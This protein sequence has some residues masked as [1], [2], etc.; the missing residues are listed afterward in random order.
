MANEL[1]DLIGPPVELVDTKR[2]TAEQRANAAAAARAL[3]EKDEALN[4][5]AKADRKLGRIV[6]G[7]ADPVAQLKAAETRRVEAI[8]PDQERIR[9]YRREVDG[10]LNLIND[11]SMQ[12][13]ESDGDVAAFV[14]KRLRPAYGDLE[15]VI[16]AITP[17]GEVPRG[18]IG[19]LSAPGIGAEKSEAAQ[20]VRMMMER[21]ATQ[22]EVKQ[23]T[24]QE[25][26]NMVKELSGNSGK[27]DPMMVM[28]MP[29]L[30]DMA[31]PQQDQSVMQLL[32]QLLMK[33]ESPQPPPP[34]VAFPMPESNQ[35]NPL[36]LMNTVLGMVNALKP[37]PP[38]PTEPQPRLL[39]Q[40][41]EAVM[42]FSPLIVPLLPKIME[43]F[44]GKNELKHQLD[45]MQ[46]EMRALR[47]KPTPVQTTG[48]SLGEMLREFNDIKAMAAQISPPQPQP[49]MTEGFWEFARETV[50][51]LPSVIGSAAAAYANKVNAGVPSQAM[52]VAQP[53]QTAQDAFPLPAK[54]DPLFKKLEETSDDQT[55]MHTM[56]MILEHLSSIKRW[57]PVV[58]IIIKRANDG[59][60]EGVIKSIKGVCEMFHARGKLSEAGASRTWKVFRNEIK[61][62]IKAI[63]GTRS[64]EQDDLES[65]AVGEPLPGEPLPD[66]PETVEASPE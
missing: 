6:G 2:E 59:N 27:L 33:L 61:T 66:Q 8:M 52:V 50:Q 25:I 22:P 60:E 30:R 5:V 43:S 20:I 36:E 42:L 26:F 53:Q 1:D 38:P 4:R 13:M 32:Q 24:P 11:Y 7:I 48:R 64:N 21:L 14:N 16:Y 65:D 37:P 12:E 31:R 34:P 55:I 41:K 51:A 49:V 54:L 9:I 40:L 39:D 45:I 56:M 47:D 15:Y 17:T 29:M 62:V 35:P 28:M 19:R 3:K 57:E 23:Q 18:T 10:K 63:N 58:N 44:G 46:L